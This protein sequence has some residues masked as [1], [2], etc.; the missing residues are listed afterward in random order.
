MNNTA[1]YSFQSFFSAG[2]RLW[3]LAVHILWLHFHIAGALLA[4]VSMIYSYHDHSF[5][6]FEYVVIALTAIFE[7]YFIKKIYAHIRDFRALA[8]APFFAGGA[9]RRVLP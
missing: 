5:F 7:W 6:P 2:R 4:L 8:A 9:D 1:D 3:L